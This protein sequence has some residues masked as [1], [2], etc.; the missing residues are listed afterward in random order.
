MNEWQAREQAHLERV[1]ALIGAHQR[2]RARHEIHPVHDFLFDYYSI[3][4]GRLRQ[5]HPGI[6]VVLQ[7]PGTERFL[8]RRGY[9]QTH[10]GVAALPGSNAPG[11]LE[12]VRWIRSLLQACVSRPPQYACFGL[13]EWAMVYRSPDRRHAAVP[14]R[15]SEE[16]IARVVETGPICCSHFDA[17]RFFTPEA[18]PLNRIQPGP[19]DRIVHEQRGCLHVN[20]DLFKWTGKLL[21][22]SSSELLLDT[23]ALAFRIREIDMRASPYDLSQYDYE[24]IRIETPGGRLAYETHQRAFAEQAL[25]LRRRLIDVCDAVLA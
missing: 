9:Q 22:W 1:G 10:D 21:P 14:L 8:Q 5:W 11:R 25:P 18:R 2:R 7:G 16:E 24:P 6:G 19:D 12:A 4:P 23:L 15:L 17:F 3:R 20:M 13:H